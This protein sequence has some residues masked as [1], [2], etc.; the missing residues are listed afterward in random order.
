[1]PKTA[2]THKT[3]KRHADYPR[4]SAAKRLYG[5]RWQKASKH[6]L[7]RN[8]LC[9]AHLAAGRTVE[10]TEVDHIIPH[11]GDMKLFWDKKNWQSLCRPCHSSK[12]RKE[13]K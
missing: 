5:R 12:T 8:R 6:F 13:S 7:K 2:R 10:A 4:P 3:Q 11:K 9:V 1:M